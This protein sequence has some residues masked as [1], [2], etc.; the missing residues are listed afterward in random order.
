LKIAPRN[1]ST[2]RGTVFERQELLEISAA[3]V[4][5]HPNALTTDPTTLKENESEQ[6]ELLPL[7]RQLTE[8]WQSIAAISK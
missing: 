2:N 5:M 1:G 3:P 7:F 4:P 6:R 8:I